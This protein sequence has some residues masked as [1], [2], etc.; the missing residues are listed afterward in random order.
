MY[1]KPGTPVRLRQD[2]TAKVWV[3]DKE[4]KYTLPSK[5]KLPEGGYYVPYFEDEKGT[6]T[7][8]K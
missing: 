7:W 3:P 4:G 2:V 6:D 8:E 5:V 1:L